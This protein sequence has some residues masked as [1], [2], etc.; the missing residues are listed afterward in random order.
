M[1]LY[2]HVLLSLETKTKLQVAYGMH[3]LPLTLSVWIP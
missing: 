2:T 3:I 1:C